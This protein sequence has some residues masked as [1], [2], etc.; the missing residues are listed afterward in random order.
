MMLSLCYVVTCFFDPHRLHHN[1]GSFRGSEKPQNLLRYLSERHNVQHRKYWVF[2]SWTAE[3]TNESRASLDC[4]S[5]TIRS[6]SFESLV[7]AHIRVSL[8]FLLIPVHSMHWESVTFSLHYLTAAKC[9]T[10]YWNLQFGYSPHASPAVFFSWCFFLF[11]G[12]YF[13]WLNVG[14]GVHETR[15]MEFPHTHTSQA[16]RRRI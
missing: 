7:A 2:F 8:A 3:R 12:C 15:K 9:D 5:H 13:R 6:L 16:T 14:L 11:C 10:K 1:I 4:L